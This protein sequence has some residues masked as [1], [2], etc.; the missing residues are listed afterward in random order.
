M[1][2]TIQ[3]SAPPPSSPAPVKRGLK[4]PTKID[5]TTV[6]QRMAQDLARKIGAA[7]SRTTPQRRSALPSG[8]KSAESDTVDEIY[9]YKD[10]VGVSLKRR[11]DAGTI[12]SVVANKDST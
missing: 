7:G 3:A 5:S 10:P 4:P 9:Q 11:T 6:Q 12:Q 2:E 8:P 1:V